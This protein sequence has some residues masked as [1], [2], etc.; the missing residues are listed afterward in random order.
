MY[1]EAARAVEPPG[2]RI[3]DELL[4][5]SGVLNQGSLHEGQ[6][7]QDG[8][9]EARHRVPGVLGDPVHHA[10]GEVLSM[11]LLKTKVGKPT[12]KNPPPGK[13]YRT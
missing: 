11:K 1:E 8:T 12:S 2:G 9:R 13:K 10:Q 3:S 6:D 4:E 5:L 7:P